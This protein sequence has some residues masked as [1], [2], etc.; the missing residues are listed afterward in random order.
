MKKG[1]TWLEILLIFCLISVLIWQCSCNTAKQNFKRVNEAILESPAQTAKQFSD[2]WPCIPIATKSDSTQL[3]AYQ[4]ELAALIASHTITPTAAETDTI[5]EI[6]ADT[7]KIK[8]LRKQVVK[9][10]EH[11]K[12]LN[13][14]ISDLTELCQEKPPVHDTIFKEDYAKLAIYQAEAEQLNYEKN[15]WLGKYEQRS[16]FAFWLII[17]LAV[18]TIINILQAKFKKWAAPNSIIK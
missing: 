18:S 7:A 10:Q 11:E 12:Y 14:Y 1:T 2:K 15:K 4:A 9:L 5:L 13:R 16:S 3:K 6:W 8:A 17:A